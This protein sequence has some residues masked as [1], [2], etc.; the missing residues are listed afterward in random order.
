MKI[1]LSIFLVYKFVSITKDKR[2]FGQ[3]IR[4]EMKN[5]ICFNVQCIENIM[6][7]RQDIQIKYW[8]E[9]RKALESYTI[10]DPN[11]RCGSADKKKNPV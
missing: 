11:G 2:I 4:I 9:Q 10:K 6:L 1:K 7:S 8:T 3:I 5:T